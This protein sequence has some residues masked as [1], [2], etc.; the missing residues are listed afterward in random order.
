MILIY[1]RRFSIRIQVRS[2]RNNW[3]NKRAWQYSKLIIG[4]FFSY[5]DDN[6]QIIIVFRSTW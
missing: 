2:K 5:H 4:K 1:A 3:A 6:D